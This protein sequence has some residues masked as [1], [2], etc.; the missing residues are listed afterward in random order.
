[1]LLEFI[2]G[3]VDVKEATQAQ[4]VLA[5]TPNITGGRQ[6]YDSDD[7]GDEDDPPQIEM[8]AA[9]HSLALNYDWDELHV[10][11]KVMCVLC[12]CDIP[13]SPDL[14]V[15]HQQ[16]QDVRAQLLHPGG[17][18]LYKCYGFGGGDNGTNHAN[19]QLSDSAPMPSPAPSPSPSAGGSVLRSSREHWSM[20]PSPASD[21]DE[22]RAH[23]DF[24]IQTCLFDLAAGLLDN[25]E[26]SIKKLPPHAD[27]KSPLEAA[28][29]AAAT[30]NGGGASTGISPTEVLARAKKVRPGRHKKY[31]ADYCL[32]AGDCLGASKQYRIA[33]D[34]SRSCQDMIWYA[35]ALEGMAGALFACEEEKEPYVSASGVRRVLSLPDPIVDLLEESLGILFKVPFASV[36]SIDGS[37]KLA[38]FLQLQGRNLDA[39]QA[40]LR[41]YELKMDCS[42]HDQIALAIE[43]AILCHSL[44]FYRKFG[45]FVIQAAG[46][47]RELHQSASCHALLK[48]VTSVYKMDDLNRNILDVSK[49]DDPT[50]QQWFHHFRDTSVSQPKEWFLQHSHM[51]GP[52]RRERADRTFN[53]WT[54]LQKTVLEHLIFSTKQMQAPEL[55]AQLTSYLLRTLHPWLDQT[56]QTSILSDL[57]A[58]TRMLPLNIDTI[59]MSGIPV[60]HSVRPLAL[61]TTLQPWIDP[62]MNTNHTN[63]TTNAESEKM[64]GTVD[65]DDDDDDDDS[66]IPPR[67]R[68]AQDAA[69]G[70]VFLTRPDATHSNA[71]SDVP[72]KYVCN[73]SIDFEVILSN[74]LKVPIL[75]Q[76]LSLVTTTS[77]SS[78]SSSSPPV[79]SPPDLVL[80]SCVISL[81]LSADARFQ[82]VLV[83][84]IPRR[85]STFDGRRLKVLGV[86]IRLANTMWIHRIDEQGKGIRPTYVRQRHRRTHRG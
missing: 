43:A 85:S 18:F 50:L 4:L 55:T 14:D 8:V 44:G 16:F 1:M 70:D 84:T 6:T 49:D 21:S 45:F 41:M 66:M 27:L 69:A 79:S 80:D 9:P 83:T 56:Y 64:T 77:S 60:I 81:T 26:A 24:F 5:P 63:T 34:A 11:A 20:I 40:I 33:A 7:D 25:F 52:K 51:Y 12:V 54:E 72:H 59:D 82:R 73:E 58:A 76:H 47:Y 15:I 67:M 75:I 86:R 38:R 22:D 36:L 19:I 37:F 74:P 23:V 30:A 32:L 28:A 17:P 35:A 62:K 48:L 61:P 78:S 39:A 2:D 65:V 71:S 13:S 10:Y 46:L 53:R 29:A 42:A 68:R 31:I 3:A 57:Y